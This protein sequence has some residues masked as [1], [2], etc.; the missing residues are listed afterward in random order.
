[1]GDISRSL[2]EDFTAV[3]DQHLATMLLVD[4]A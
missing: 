2:A 4:L 3:I 1:M